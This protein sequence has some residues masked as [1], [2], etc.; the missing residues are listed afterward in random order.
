MRFPQ[1]ALVLYLSCSVMNPPAASENALRESHTNRPND[2]S[3]TENRRIE[4]NPDTVAKSQG[5]H[6]RSDPVLQL[7]SQHYDRILYAK[8]DGVVCDGATDITR[9]AQAA[10]A[11]AV[12]IGGTDLIFPAGVCLF[13]AAFP[14]GRA[15]RGLGPFNLKVE[16]AKKLRIRGA[17][18]E[19]TTFE[20]SP[21]GNNAV[22]LWVNESEDIEINNISFSG[23]QTGLTHGQFSTALCLYSV[24][25]FRVS[26]VSSDDKFNGSVI[27]GNWQFNGV[28]Q[29]ISQRVSPYS[30]GFDVASLQNIT[31]KDWTATG[32]GISSQGLHLIFDPPN[33]HSDYNRTGVSLRGD[34]SNAIRIINFSLSKFQS[35]IVIESADDVIIRDGIIKKNAPLSSANTTNF[36]SGV[37][38]NGAADGVKMRNIRIENTLFVANG[39]PNAKDK[40][41]NG[42]ILLNS[43]RGEIQVSVAGSTFIDN[44][45]AAIASLG[46]STFLDIKRSTFRN[47]A[48]SSLKGENISGMI[49][50]PAGLTD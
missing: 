8:D 48:G 1:L 49:R 7:Q 28:Y 33:A 13:G 5:A 37:T 14:S 34:R 40:P 17:E 35:A 6:P 39:N 15:E 45:V 16:G 20:Q 19:K 47:S 18:K 36:W 10:I 12:A 26:D 42:G 3:L 29:R 21:S 9:K 25:N 43:N 11:R 46:R 50:T 44:S 41:L 2:A 24:K 23:N 31:F 30:S 22:I 4:S 38:I 32:S 27:H